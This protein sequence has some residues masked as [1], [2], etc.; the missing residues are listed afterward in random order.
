M[1]LA[2]LSIWMTLFRILGV[3]GVAYHFYLILD[4]KKI[5]Y[6]N[7]VDPDRTP[8]SAASDLGLQC[9]PRS[10]KRTPSSYGLTSTK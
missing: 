7:S 8:H 2:I 5:L 3:S 1:D 6:A 10:Q 4:R 9:L